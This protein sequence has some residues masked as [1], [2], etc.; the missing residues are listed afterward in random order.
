MLRGRYCFL[1]LL[2]LFFFFFF[3]RRERLE[4]KLLH[5]I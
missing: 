1:L 4:R 3:F 5:I 2:L